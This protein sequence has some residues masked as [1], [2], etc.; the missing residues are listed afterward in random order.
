MA[1]PSILVPPRSI[2]IRIFVATVHL[3][4]AVW[5]A[6]KTRSDDFTSLTGQ[7]TLESLPRKEADA[8]ASVTR[9]VDRARRRDACA[10][11]LCCLADCKDS[12]GPPHLPTLP[13]AATIGSSEGPSPQATET[14]PDRPSRPWWFQTIRCPRR[15]SLWTI[16]PGGSRA[17][18]NG[19]PNGITRDTLNRSIQGAMGS[20]A[21]CFSA[22]TQ[23]PMVSVSF[24]ADPSGKPSLVR[25]GGAPR[26]PSAAFAMWCRT[27]AFPSFEGKGVQ[28][29]LPLSFHRVAHPTQSGSPA[30]G[31][32]P[33]GAPLFLRPARGESNRAVRSGFGPDVRT[34]T[35]PNTVSR[36]V[37]TQNP[38]ERRRGDF[39]HGLLGARNACRAWRGT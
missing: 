10:A 26:M 5:A 6:S 15:C 18:L 7:V 39:H 23:D 21:A 34:A 38:S 17:T 25:V 13:T 20:F 1:M 19:D 36:T 9:Q 4:S 8:H 32:Q 35:A 16:K 2:P 3:S 27:S 22:L 11:L 12:H 31:Q 29:D 37:Q 24:E 28:V 33:L 14:S 30:A